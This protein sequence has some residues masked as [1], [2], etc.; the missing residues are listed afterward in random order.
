MI[1]KVPVGKASINRIKIFLHPLHELQIIQRPTFY[2]FVNF[3][4]LHS[5]TTTNQFQ[6]LL[7][8]ISCQNHSWQRREKKRKKEY[9]IKGETLVILSLLKTS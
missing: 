2:E 5:R 4:M 6:T 9:R 1:D 7:T 3:Y 8:L